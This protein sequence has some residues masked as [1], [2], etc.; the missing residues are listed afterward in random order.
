MHPTCVSTDQD[1]ADS[2]DREGLRAN[3][4]LAA[5]PSHVADDPPFVSRHDVDI[6]WRITV[7][8]LRIPL[9][10]L[11]EVLAVEE[12]AKPIQIGFSQL[13]VRDDLD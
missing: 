6:M 4:D 1:A 13:L 10:E 11:L 9:T 7:R 2:R 8:L 12:P 3:S 5:P